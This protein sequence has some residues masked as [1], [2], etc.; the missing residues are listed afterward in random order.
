MSAGDTLLLRTLAASQPLLRMQQLIKEQQSTIE[1][2]QGQLQAMEKERAEL[3]GYLLESHI[4][5]PYKRFPYYQ[6]TRNSSASAGKASGSVPSSA[7]K[8][9]EAMVQSV[10]IVDSLYSRGHEEWD[11][12]DDREDETTPKE[13]AVAA[14]T[15]ASPSL[16]ESLFGA[17]QPSSSVLVS[18]S[19]VNRSTYR[20]GTVKE[21]L[22]T[23]EQIIRFTNGDVKR[24]LP[25]PD[26]HGKAIDSSVTGAAVV[27]YYYAAAKT[28]HTT[29]PDGKEV[30]EFEN[31]QVEEHYSDGSKFV[32]FPNGATKRIHPNGVEV[33]Y[34]PL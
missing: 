7:T 30:Y 10:P 15:A 3:R 34:T 4:V 16:A 24:I 19:V 27:K 11:D 18:E 31:G 29:Y 17:K 20:N 13:E 9:L 26:S 23:G 6:P 28:M 33:R 32:K 12:A 25:T 5:L 21:W 1:Q 22:A 2:Q 14:V 8:A